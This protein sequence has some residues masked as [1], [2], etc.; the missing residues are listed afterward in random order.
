MKTLGIIGL[1]AMGHPIAV[2]LKKQ[3]Y[4]LYTSV[5]SQRS[6]EKAEALGIHVLDSHRDFA[7]HT[8]RI[9]MIVSNYDQCA[10]C[11]LGSDGV[12][13][14]MTEGTIILVSTVSPKDAATLAEA[15][16]DGVELVDAPVSGG[17]AGAEKGILTTMTAGKREAVDACRDVFDCYCRKVI[18]VGDK[19]GQ[20]QSVKAVN[21][22]LV[23]IH[24]T[25]TAEAMALSTALGIDPNAM[26][27]TIS[28]CSGNSVIFQSR[29]PKLIGKNFT[30][31]ASL[32]TLQKDMKICMDLAASANVPCYLTEMCHDMFCRTPRAEDVAED[33]CAV[34]RL[35]QLEM[36]Q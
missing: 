23:G 16:P 18:Y 8:N 5:R 12:L 15:C 35:Y 28:E 32:E 17:A 27:E 30:S 20:A 19:P 9:L 26:F 21:Q 7:A 6:R 33:A 24:M 25:A 13:S 22:M 14:T 1:G 29:M 34:I 11:L 36:E 4:E 3:G 10:E 31:R 2:L